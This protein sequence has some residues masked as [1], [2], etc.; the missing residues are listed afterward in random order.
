MVFLAAITMLTALPAPWL[1]AS[2]LPAAGPQ[3]EIEML[4]YFWHVRQFA[5]GE[6]RD[7]FYTHML[8]YPNGTSLALSC[9]P[10]TF[11][12]ALLPVTLLVKGTPG[13]FL[14]YNL[15]ILVSFVLTGYFV[16]LLVRAVTRSAPAGVVSGAMVAC[17]PYCYNHLSR[18]HLL[19]YCWVPLFLYFLWRLWQSPSK[20]AALL[21]VVC[22]VACAYTSLQ[23]LVQ[24]VGAF[25]LFV[26]TLSV[27]D[28]KKW[29]DR[30]LRV[31]LAGLAAGVC[32]AVLLV[33]IPAMLAEPME[34]V[35]EVGPRF[36]SKWWSLNVRELAIPRYGSILAA[37]AGGLG[38]EIHPGMRGSTYVGVSLVAL[39]VL[40]FVHHR[41]RD[42]WLWLVMA[43]AFLALSLGAS[44]KVGESTYVRDMMPYSW[45]RRWVPVLVWDRAPGRLFRTAHLAL[46]VLAGLGFAFLFKVL[47]DRAGRAGVFLL[48][49]VLAAVIV[50]Y[51]PTN[52]QFWSP[53]IPT[54]Y[55][56]IAK[57]LEPVAV[58]P[59][60]GEWG[61]KRYHMLYQTLH[62]K[63]ITG[64]RIVRRCAAAGL[65]VEGMPIA[66]A[67]LTPRPG[68][69][70][71][72]EEI[73][74]VLMENR[75]KYVVLHPV[76]SGSLRLETDRCRLEKWLEVVERTDQAVLFRVF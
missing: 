44:L 4:W 14:A 18:L 76:E 31:S 71:R 49:A 72:I 6:V 54:I 57:D 20:K 24:L 43:T 17:H 51:V 52:V 73:R 26:L 55:E 69:R 12:F 35:G 59:L 22:A 75:V 10:W 29:R 65:T 67:M 47:R 19:A 16:F 63:P 33:T 5:L 42:R 58:C 21:A 28:R 37:L 8:F 53:E 62:G 7:L 50:E 56:T 45:L 74:R 64:G 61:V 48:P 23:Y 40:G 25:V 15:F 60:P 2:H 68:N 27:L 36:C 70:Q 46:A 30:R 38:A 9:A 3:D 11:A 66:R 32:V 41:R 13:L 39:S 1:W 34:V